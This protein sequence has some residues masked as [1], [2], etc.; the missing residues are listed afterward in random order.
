MLVS[1]A[2]PLTMNNLPPGITRSRGIGDGF[3][4]SPRRDFDGRQAALRPMCSLR[5][6][7]G[8]ARMMGSEPGRGRQRTDP[9]GKA[10]NRPK[11]SKASWSKSAPNAMPMA[12]DAAE[13][14]ATTLE[15]KIAWMRERIHDKRGAVDRP[16]KKA[17]DRGTDYL[18][19]E[20]LTRRARADPNGRLSRTLRKAPH[21]IYRRL[22]MLFPK[23]GLG[24]H[25]I[26]VDPQASPG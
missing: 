13:D 1:Q 15:K 23:S 4:A 21:P 11:G 26:T 14:G 25:D 17:E 6:A 3:R 8:R 16:T 10:A 24:P 20:F 7:G 9:S 19:G 12:D 2:Q 22:C 5:N 18:T